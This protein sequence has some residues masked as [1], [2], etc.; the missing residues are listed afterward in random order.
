MTADVSSKQ[1]EMY[2]PLHMSRC[3]SLT[4]EPLNTCSG[5]IP[6]LQGVKDSCVRL[7]KQAMS[8]VQFF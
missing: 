3:E 4:C 1:V 7:L 2:F 8:A 6:T 5:T